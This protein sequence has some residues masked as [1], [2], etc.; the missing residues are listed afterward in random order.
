MSPWVG[1]WVPTEHSGWAAGLR[2]RG[3]VQ[4]GA[5]GIWGTVCGATA[6]VVRLTG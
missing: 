3:C 6:Q 1:A 2:G 4:Y 5:C